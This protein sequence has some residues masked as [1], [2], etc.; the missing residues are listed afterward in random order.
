MGPLIVLALTTA[1][2]VT[3][4]QVTKAWVTRGAPE[5]LRESSRRVGLRP[6][7]NRRGAPV[8]LPSAAAAVVWTAIAVGVGVG[9]VLGPA[10]QWS[11]VLG[12]GFA[13]GGAAGNLIDRIVGEGVVDFI[14]VGRWPAF[15]LSDSALV[16]G[17]A[18]CA[19][20]LV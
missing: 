7:T 17:T 16:A 13:L 5:R 11:A 6:S 18:L 12:L 2:V 14:V 20:S 9:M 15:N 8:P 10:A 4:D 1:A 19:W 3:C